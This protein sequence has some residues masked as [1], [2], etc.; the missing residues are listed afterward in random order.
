MS[1]EMQIE[2]S[3]VSEPEVETKTT[4]TPVAEPEAPDSLVEEDE[5]EEEEEEEEE[6][7]SEDGKKVKKGGKVQKPDAKY[8]MPDDYD[9]RKKSNWTT[10]AL[11]DGTNIA[12]E[13]ALIRYVS[14]T[15]CCERTEECVKK[16]A[17]TG[18]WPNKKLQ[19]LWNMKRDLK[20]TYV[21]F[22]EAAEQQQARKAEAGVKATEEKKAQL[23]SFENSV[24]KALMAGLKAAA[25][26]GPLEQMQSGIDGALTVF[27]EWAPKVNS[28][29]APTAT[30]A[31]NIIIGATN[32][33]ESTVRAILDAAPTEETKP[34]DEEPKAT[35][36]G[37]KRPIAEADGDK[38]MVTPKKPKGESSSAGSQKPA[39]AAAKA[40]AKAKF[41]IGKIGDKKLTA[42]TATAAEE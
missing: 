16:F 20:D 4:D 41:R 8:P 32:M 24:A 5:D 28:W 14:M 18:T 7:T 30:K 12:A 42:A 21:H 26:K 36:D 3:P 23:G 39:H 9:E 6:V 40:G 34:K 37:C 31:V 38:A 1:T 2:N 29:S 17:S 15:E 13:M 11:P 33:E 35:K 10:E 27:K 25:G 22:K 19:T